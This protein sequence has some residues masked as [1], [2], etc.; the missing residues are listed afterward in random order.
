[1]T[2]LIL[3]FV[4]AANAQPGADLLKPFPSVVRRNEVLAFKP[5]SGHHFGLEAPQKCG[6][7]KPV[8]ASARFIKCQFLTAGEASATLNV[9]DDA[10]TFCKP[11]PVTLRVSDETAPDPV[12]LVKNENL[13]HETKKTLVPGFAV[14]TPEELAAQ[15]LKNKK[16]VFVMVSTDWCPPCN[17][18]KEYLL[19]SPGFLAATKD[20]FKVYVDGDSLSSVAWE[21]R[22]PYRY[23]PSFVLLNDRFEEVAR[24]NGELRQ[25]DFAQWAEENSRYLNDPVAHLQRRVVA[26]KDG[27]VMQK[28][29]DLFNSANPASRHADEV[30]WLKWALDRKH[31]VPLVKKVMEGG[32]HPEL[33]I[34]MVRHQLE[35]LGEEPKPDKSRQVALAKDLAEA[36]FKGED[37]AQSIV[38]LC[39]LDAAA[40]KSYVAK[41]PERLQFLNSRPGLEDSERASM[42]GEELFFVTY[43]FESLNDK[44]KQKEFANKCVDALGKLSSMTRLKLGRGAQ[45]TQMACYEMAGRYAEAEA[46]LK[47]LIETYPNEPTFMVR[48]ARLFRK[49]KKLD[50]ALKW[51]EKSENVSYGF[52]WFSGQM[53]KSDILLD[54]KREHDAAKVLE[55][56]LIEVRLSEDQSNRN[57]IVA[58]RLRTAQTKI[59]ELKNRKT[60]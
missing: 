43:L 25:A 33:K 50:L 22:V 7:N 48:M 9:C 29:K 5:K 2:V 31:D 45:Q 60:N 1:M 26:R 30:R 16:P 53:I 18:A 36:T 41:I 12:R 28:L 11:V 21:K 14:G 51:I 59:L 23:Y 52:N 24:F 34:E 10:K 32:S 58:S 54:L 3:G 40:C 13:N 57:Q 8:E 39:D 17:E 47:T 46:Q 55:D 38:E 44:A 27:S 49:Q 56:A 35:L 20:W 15:A 42:L 19:Q 4:L 6:G 37:W